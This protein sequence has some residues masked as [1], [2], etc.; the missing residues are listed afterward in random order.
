M[1]RGRRCRDELRSPV[2]GRNIERPGR[3]EKSRRRRCGAVPRRL[4]SGT[5]VPRRY[6]YGIRR[7]PGDA[8]ALLRGRETVD[9]GV[10]LATPPATSESAMCAAMKLVS[11]P[12]CWHRNSHSD[13]LL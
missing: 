8:T 4:V 13:F 7:I 1:A 5:I 6:Q 12:G 10:V 11:L 3:G 9:A 2:V